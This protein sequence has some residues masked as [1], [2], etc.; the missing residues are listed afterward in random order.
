MASIMDSYTACVHAKF[1]PR[2][3]HSLPLIQFGSYFQFL[4]GLRGVDQ[5]Q[6]VRVTDNS[7][8]IE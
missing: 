2:S 3:G 7:N 1:E 5:E 4:T 8:V 6:H